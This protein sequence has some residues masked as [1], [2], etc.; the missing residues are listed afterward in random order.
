MPGPR[1]GGNAQ[2]TEPRE[3]P[4]PE[5]GLLLG[6]RLKDLN[7]EVAGDHESRDWRRKCVPKDVERVPL[8]T[9]REVHGPEGPRALPAVV[10]TTFDSAAGR[11]NSLADDARAMWHENGYTSSGDATG[12]GMRVGE[13]H[14]RNREQAS[15]REPLRF[16][17]VRLLDADDLSRNYRVE[18]ELPLERRFERGGFDP[19]GIPGVTLE[20]RCGGAVPQPSNNGINGRIAT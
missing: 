20:G 17:P 15:P 12:V 6:A 13:R 18:N 9:R 5:P 1:D 7:V 3:Q 8:G 11:K 14:L 16:R 2:L 19:L 4:V 10:S